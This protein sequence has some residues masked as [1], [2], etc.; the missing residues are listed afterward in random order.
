MKYELTL[1][2]PEEAELKN[3]TQIIT[4]LK[5]KIDSEEKWDK[6]TLSYPIKK[7]RSA[8]FFNL[9]LTLDQDKVNSLKKNLNFN[10]KLMRFL[11]LKMT[12]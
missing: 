12:Q 5:G 7:Q 6:K 11:L 9:Q 10:E 1:L 4:S 8:H 2:L 3:I